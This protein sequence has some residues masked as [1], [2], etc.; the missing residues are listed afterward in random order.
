MEVDGSLEDGTLGTEIGG[1][2]R[3]AKEPQVKESKSKKRKVERET[4][5]K[6]VKKPK[7]T[8]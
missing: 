3:K 4:V 6:T 2:P 5:H 8:E 7:T 1:S